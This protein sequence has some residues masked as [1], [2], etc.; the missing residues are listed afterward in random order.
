MFTLTQ[1]NRDELTSIIRRST[2]E[3]RLVTRAS[4]VLAAEGRTIKAAANELGCTWL[5]VR[6]WDRRYLEQGIE[7]LKDTQRSGRPERISAEIKAK[8]LST[9]ETDHSLN[10]CRKVAAKLGISR[11]TVNRL[12]RQH[13]IKPHLHKK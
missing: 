1:Q 8:I 7:G 5:T 9:P 2:A 3:H 10:S 13:G 4:I 6:K 11:S 12:W